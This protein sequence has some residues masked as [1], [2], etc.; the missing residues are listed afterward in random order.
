ML[1]CVKTVKQ[2]TDSGPH[3]QIQE[4]CCWV[5]PLQDN[6]NFTQTSLQLNPVNL[7]L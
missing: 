2:Q 6:L 7:S 5:S 4:I 1:I 3:G